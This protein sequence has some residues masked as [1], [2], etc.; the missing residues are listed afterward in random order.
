MRY[1]L[2]FY[3]IEFLEYKAAYSKINIVNMV[4]SNQY[5]NIFRLLDI[6]TAYQNIKNAYQVI[7]ILKCS[8]R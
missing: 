4:Y 2:K 5:L 8:P 1:L 3:R 7:K 6:K